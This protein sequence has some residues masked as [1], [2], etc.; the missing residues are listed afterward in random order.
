MLTHVDLFSGIGGFALAARWAGFR[1]V[2]FCEIDE[3]CQEVLKARFGATA[4]TEYDGFITPQTRNRRIKS[5][6][7][8]KKESNGLKQSSG[9]D[10]QFTLLIP[11]IR[12]FDGTRFR[13]AT[14]L[15]GGFPCQP[16]SCAGKRRGKKDDRWLWPEMLRVIEEARPRWVLAENVAGIINMGLEEVCADLE[17]EGYEVQPIV[18]PACAV[19]APHRRDRVWIIAYG[20]NNAS[21]DGLS[22]QYSKCSSQDARSQARRSRNTVGESNS[23]APLAQDSISGRNGRGSKGNT[24]RVRLALQTQGSDSDASDTAR[25]SLNGSGGTW[26]R[27]KKC[28]N[29]SGGCSDSSKNAIASLTIKGRENMRRAVQ[30]ISW[31][32]PWT[33]IAARLCRVDDGLPAWIHRHRVQR[34]RA[35]GNSIVPQVAYQIIKGIA[36][37][38][39]EF[40]QAVS[41]R[42]SGRD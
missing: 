30:E 13:G 18:I 25:F 17:G 12:D 40:E 8:R 15:T 5:C 31:D 28:S 34:L 20:K 10:C 9:G 24:L 21:F 33:E 6:A 16:V 3:F 29:G 19:N 39:R 27:R 37:I 35:L 26:E 7:R 42:P 2:V 23:D 1:T 4:N 11:D 38:E 32:I 36:M 22:T 14:L 41:L